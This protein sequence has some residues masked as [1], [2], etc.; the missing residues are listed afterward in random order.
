MEGQYTPRFCR[1]LFSSQILHRCSNALCNVQEGLVST[2]PT[3]NGLSIFGQSL[4]GAQ[5]G[6][7][8]VHRTKDDGDNTRITG[9][10]A[11]QGFLHLD[12]IAVLRRDELGADQQ[13]D[14]ISRE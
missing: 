2:A 1:L 12:P 7:F 5:W 13:Q 14:E 4:Q 11:L 8:P 10:V 3:R 9:R 6:H